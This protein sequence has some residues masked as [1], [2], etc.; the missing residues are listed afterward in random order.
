MPRRIQLEDSTAK[1]LLVNLNA[2]VSK[3]LWKRIRV[4]CVTDETLLRD[5]ITEALRD[6]LKALTVR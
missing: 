3:D 6:R 4:R 5:F 1:E 2:R